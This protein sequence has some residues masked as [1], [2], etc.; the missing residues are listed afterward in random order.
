MPLILVIHHKISTKSIEGILLHFIL[1]LSLF[2]YFVIKCVY[3]E[4]SKSE[5]KTI[6]VSLYTSSETTK[7]PQV[8]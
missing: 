4:K 3:L 1:W 2:T 5:N 6:K 8:V 7:P